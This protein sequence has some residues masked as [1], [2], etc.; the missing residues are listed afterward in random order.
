[1]ERTIKDIINENIVRID[2]Q[3]GDVKKLIID[4]GNT[5][6]EQSKKIINLE[7]EISDYKNSL[8]K[9]LGTE[10]PSDGGK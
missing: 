3:N 10:T 5:I 7:K 1:M 8:K 4:L 2:A 6:V 9:L